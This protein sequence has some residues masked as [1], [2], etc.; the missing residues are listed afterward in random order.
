LFGVVT[1]MTPLFTIG[2]DS[3]TRALAGFDRPDLLQ[4]LTFFVLILSSGL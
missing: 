2:A 1:N 4:T 3:W